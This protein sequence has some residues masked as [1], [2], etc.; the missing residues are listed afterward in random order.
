M[1][2][3]RGRL[4]PNPTNKENTRMEPEASDWQ[5]VKKRLEKLERYNR[6]MKLGGGLSVGS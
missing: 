1:G 2:R 4:S 5:A 6:R 3:C